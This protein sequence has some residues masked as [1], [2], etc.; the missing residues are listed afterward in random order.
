MEQSPLY[1]EFLIPEY[2]SLKEIY[3]ISDIIAQ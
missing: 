3:P 2:P 1:F